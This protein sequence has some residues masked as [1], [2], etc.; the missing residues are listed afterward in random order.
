L[1]SQLEDAKK[2]AKYVEFGLE[3]R[4]YAFVTFHRPSNVDEI[5]VLTKIVNQLLWLSNM[6]PV[7][8]SVHP[9]TKKQLEKVQ[10]YEMLQTQQN[11]HLAEPLSYI[12]GLSMTANAKVVITDSGGLQEETSF[13]HVPCL[14]LRDNTE[15]PITIEEG[16]N[17]LIAGDWMQF[18]KKIKEIESGVYLKGMD[19][20]QLW[21][22]LAAERILTVLAST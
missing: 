2:Q 1:L 22:G 19:K 8:F 16:S 9:R 5:A 21:D 13:L 3:S 14:T 10:L 12:E 20:I 6:M 17:T 15:R 11:V 7:V 4:Q 18:R